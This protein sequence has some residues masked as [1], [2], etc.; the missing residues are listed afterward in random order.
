MTVPGWLGAGD[1]GV[2]GM[3]LNDAQV[4]RRLYDN[5]YVSV[6]YNGRGVAMGTAAGTLLADLSAGADSRL[7]SDIQDLRK[8]SWLPFEPF[9]GMG[10]SSYTTYL[11]HHAGEEG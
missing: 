10:V 6:A 1:L 9:L 3:S 5:I 7:L 11:Y 2:M 4:F 8:P